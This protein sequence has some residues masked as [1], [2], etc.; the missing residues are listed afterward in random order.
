MLN[1]LNF[2]KEL[3]INIASVAFL[4]FSIVSIV[5]GI[6]CAL[7]GFISGV[8]GNGWSYFVGGLITIVIITGLVITVD[9]M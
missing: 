2:I 6:I 9:N 7:Y 1:I 5:A 4:V 3:C 8:A